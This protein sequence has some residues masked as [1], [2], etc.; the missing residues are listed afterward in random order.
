MQ[1]C[2][3]RLQLLKPGL[4]L[5]LLPACIHLQLLSRVTPMRP[6]LLL[7]PS[8]LLLL[9]PGLLLQ[10]PILLLL[11]PVTLLLLLHQLAVLLLHLL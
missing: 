4:L 7:L 6:L 1:L 3:L 9:L 5:L 10:V 11:L 2:K 8:L